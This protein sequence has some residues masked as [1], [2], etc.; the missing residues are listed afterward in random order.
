MDNIW[1]KITSLFGDEPILTYGRL[2]ELDSWVWH[3][4]SDD[5]SVLVRVIPNGTVGHVVLECKMAKGAILDRHRHDYNENFVILSGVLKDN[6]SNVLMRADG[7]L[8]PYRSG[9]PHEPHAIEDCHMLI[10]CKSVNR[11]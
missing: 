1:S 6:V 11:H 3:S 4:F 7:K 8:H 10:F 9:T 5:D 2:L